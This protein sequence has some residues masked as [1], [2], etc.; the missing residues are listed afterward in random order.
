MHPLRK[1]MG[2]IAFFCEKVHVFYSYYRPYPPTLP[3]KIDASEKKV[4]KT[5]FSAKNFK[6]VATTY[7]SHSKMH[8]PQ[9]KEKKSLFC[10]KVQ[11]F[12]SYY[13]PYPLTLPI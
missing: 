10:E 5:A 1:R 6:F 13:R 12:Y 2:K 4:E 11:V 3:P 7:L 8:P 9:K